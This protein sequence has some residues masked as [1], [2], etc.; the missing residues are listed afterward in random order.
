MEKWAKEDIE[1][2]VM[3]IIESRYLAFQ[4]QK[5]N[6]DITL[7]TDIRKDLGF[8]SIMLVVL[9]IDIEDALGIRFNPIEDDSRAIFTTI[10]NI[11][12]YVKK[13]LGE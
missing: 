6:V 2:R 12:S 3:K 7:D 8:D 4:D 5:E 1:L 13:C 11:S 10:R 9:Q